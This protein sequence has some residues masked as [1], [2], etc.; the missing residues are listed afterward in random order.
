MQLAFVFRSLHCKTRS[1]N[2]FERWTIIAA[3]PRWA[4]SN[5]GM[6]QKKKPV[7]SLF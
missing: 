1:M 6:A 2:R 5:N 7:G 3:I 4:Y